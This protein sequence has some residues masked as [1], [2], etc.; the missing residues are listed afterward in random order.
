MC[1]FAL[2]NKQTVMTVD[3][4]N[5]KILNAEVKAMFEEDMKEVD[6]TSFNELALVRHCL[7]TG[8]EDYIRCAKFRIT[9][10]YPEFSFD[11]YK[12]KYPK[13]YE[14]FI[15]RV[16]IEII[17]WYAFFMNNSEHKDLFE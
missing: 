17:K 4:V 5:I 7:L 2:N 14:C 1:I 12:E 6:T 8:E 3:T 10:K 11:E 15:H 9:R 16:K 13:G